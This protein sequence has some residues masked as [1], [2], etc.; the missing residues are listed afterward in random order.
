MNGELRKDIRSIFC[1]KVVC[2][3]PVSKC[4]TAQGTV[5]KPLKCTWLK[6]DFAKS[7]T[8]LKGLWQLNRE[9]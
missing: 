8:P 1:A 7:R 6:D 3:G 5:V 9:Y 2:S 4:F